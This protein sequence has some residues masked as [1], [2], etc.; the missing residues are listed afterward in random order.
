MKRRK[1]KE[2]ERRTGNQQVSRKEIWIEE[3]ERKERKK[4]RDL[5]GAW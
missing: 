5:R 3:K 2:L 4:R 1:R